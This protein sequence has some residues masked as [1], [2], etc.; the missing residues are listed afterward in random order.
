MRTLERPK[1]RYGADEMFSLDGLPDVDSLDT[2]IAS[3]Y[4]KGEY[5]DEWG[6][7]DQAASNG[8]EL[9]A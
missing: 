8:S 3:L 2:R 6:G 4:A 1:E 5:L 7:F 9:L